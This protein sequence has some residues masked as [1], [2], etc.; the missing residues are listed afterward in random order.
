MSGAIPAIERAYPARDNEIIL[1]VLADGLAIDGGA[2]TRTQLAL[3]PDTGADGFIIDSDV[4][5]GVFDW[6]RG[7]GVLEILLIN[8]AG[9]VSAG[10]YT[11]RL[12]VYD[13]DHT[14]GLVWG[15]AFT[16]INEAV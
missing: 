2:V 8:V 5:A 15:R 12:V 11:A 10:R 13:A 1:Q 9:G 3:T 16:I 14:N 7:G 4:D 6:S